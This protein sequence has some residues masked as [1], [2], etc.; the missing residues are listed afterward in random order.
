MKVVIA[1]S[2]MRTKNTILKSRTA[3]VGEGEIVCAWADRRSCGWWA[4]CCCLTC[5]N[6]ELNFL[7]STQINCQFCYM[8]IAQMFHWKPLH[9]LLSLLKQ[10]SQLL[11]HES[12][13][14]PCSH[15]RKQLQ[16][17]RY[18]SQCSTRVSVG[19]HLVLVGNFR[20]HPKSMPL[21][22]GFGKQTV[23]KFQCLNSQ[24]ELKS[25]ECSFR[26]DNVAIVKLLELWSVA[27]GTRTKQQ[28]QK[29]LGSNCGKQTFHFWETLVSLTTDCRVEKKKCKYFGCFVIGLV[30]WII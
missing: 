12:L 15:T 10:Y 7:T 17:S 29:M 25:P 3:S 14:I 1:I 20:H 2:R 11:Q 4:W 8:S 21:Q 24:N 30:R 23:F 6:G 18:M 9:I 13:Y 5:S 16:L 26:Q 22:S 27:W 28:R 19:H